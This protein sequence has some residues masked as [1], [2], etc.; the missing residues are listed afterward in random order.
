[1]C[2]RPAWTW[3]CARSNQARLFL[4]LPEP[5]SKLFNKRSSGLCERIENLAF[6]ERFGGLY[7]TF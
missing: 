7:V 5:I 6:Y 2:L 3:H 4:N 1:M